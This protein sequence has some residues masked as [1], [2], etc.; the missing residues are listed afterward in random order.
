[1]RIDPAIVAGEVVPEAT[2]KTI[3]GTIRQAGGT[4]DDIRLA[5]GG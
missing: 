4:T 2:E 1:M 5:F 3:P